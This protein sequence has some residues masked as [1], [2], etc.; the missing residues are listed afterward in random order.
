MKHLFFILFA[1]LSLPLA[2]APE[3]TLRLSSAHLVKGETT[4]LRIYVS[5][6]YLNQD[7]VIGP[8]EGLTIE[9]VENGQE[10]TLAEKGQRVASYV[11]KITA[12][13]EGSYRIPS[14][15]LEANTTALISPEQ[16][17]TVHP[18]SSLEEEFLEFGDRKHPYLT[19]LFLEEDTLYPNQ[20][21][22]AELKFYFPPQFGLKAPDVP[23]LAQAQNLAAWRFTPPSMPYSLGS[24][25]FGTNHHEVYT[26]TTYCNGLQPGKASFGDITTTFRA[27]VTTRRPGIFTSRTRSF[28]L[29]SGTAEFEVLPFPSG[30]PAGFSGAVGS[31]GLE[32][33]VPAKLSIK[34]SESVSVRLRISG[35]G[36]MDSI[37]QPIMDPESPWDSIDVSEV[38]RGE[39]RKSNTGTLEFDYL[40]QPNGR[41]KSLP[42]FHFVYF[43]PKLEDYVVRSTQEI[44]ITITKTL[45]TQTSAATPAAAIP[46]EAMGDILGIIEPVRSESQSSF[47]SSLPTWWW[48]I[49]PALLALV[50]ILHAIRR[51]LREHKLKNSRNIML[52]KAYKELQNTNKG[53]YRAAGAFV[54]KWLGQKD[55]EAIQHILELRDK[56]CFSAGEMPEPSS[57]EKRSIIKS[58]KPLLALCLSFYLFTPP[59][60][61]AAPPQAEAAPA[62]EETSASAFEAWQQQD[63]QDALKLYASLPT[64][65]DA[66]FNQGNCWYRLDQPGKAA[67]HYHRALLHDPKHPEALQN[68]RYLHR[69]L[70]SL[71]PPEKEPLEELISR[72]PKAF[73]TQATY[74]TAWLLVLSALCLWLFRP[75]GSR[76]AS[77]VL[78]T[79]LSAI[80]LPLAIYSSRQY[81]EHLSSYAH[82]SVILEDE[83]SAY[84]EPLNHSEQERA[85]VIQAPPASLCEVITQRGDWC[86]VSFLQGSRG[87]VRQQ[88]IS[89]IQEEK[90]KPL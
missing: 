2:A 27:Q 30:A 48:Q 28:P 54:E 14:L 23:E 63:Y 81:P 68:L 49:I 75:R 34:D 31:Y 66:E 50:M 15:K 72:L 17:I 70:G 26:F 74:A 5:E 33:I 32:A 4:Y 35:E 1:L 45:T 46:L 76:L 59:Q 8:I 77:L 29:T 19:K 16:K 12:L 11:F 38:Q 86:Y 18:R 55:H 22:R 6:N 78:L 67:L 57:Q 58:L 20:P 90:E 60:V 65:A 25:P 61:E 42:S 37:T 24:L 21:Q 83:V 43:D 80:I 85:A 44:P 39:E 7:P 51:K 56:H 71:A 62:Q 73:Y 64:S 52:K 88:E 40:L 84:T 10:V 69:S 36:N 89:A 79:T 9:Q 82:L 47:W 87:W 53:F 13:K 3:L 41:T